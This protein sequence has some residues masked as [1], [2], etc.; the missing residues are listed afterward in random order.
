MPSPERPSIS[1][2]KGCC[3]LSA[4]S[5]WR[6]RKFTE[7]DSLSLLQEVLKHAT[8]SLLPK[9]DLDV[10]LSSSRLKIESIVKCTPSWVSGQKTRKWKGKSEFYISGRSKWFHIYR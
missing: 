2:A 6:A 10:L 4:M 1:V 8:K 7:A 5:D 3:S 9:F